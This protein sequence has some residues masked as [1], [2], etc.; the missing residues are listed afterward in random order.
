MA[1]KLHVSNLSNTTSDQDLRPLFAQVMTPE[2]ERSGA[3]VVSAASV[4]IKD[5]FNH[6]STGFAVVR[7]T[8]QV[9]TR[10][11]IDP[12]NA[13]RPDERLLTASPVKPHHVRRSGRPRRSRP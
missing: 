13:Y 10:K 6:A 8:T 1:Y 3:D 5:D 7:T 11:A 2:A 9:D 4:I 12:F